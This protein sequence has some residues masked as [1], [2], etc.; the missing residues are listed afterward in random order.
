MPYEQ[1]GSNIV[2]TASAAEMSDFNKNPFI[3]FTGGFPTGFLPSFFLK[4]YWYPPIESDRRGIAKYAPYGLRKIEASLIENGFDD[5]DVAVVHPNDLDR[6]VGSKTRVVG[7]STMDPLGMGFVSS[8]YSSLLGI[9]EPINAM[10]FRKLMQ[11]R[12]LR[13]YK[14]KIIIGGA[15]SWQ[16]ER[17][18]LTE[19]LGVDCVIIGEG[20]EVA[21]EIF[22]KAVRGEAL[23]RV[24]YAK[25]PNYE[26][27]PSI[28]R[29]S[30]YGCV[31]IS[32]GCE[33]N[34]Q[35]CTPTTRH[36]I[37]FPLD[38]IMKEVEI[39]AEGGSNMILLNTEDA[40]L[41][42][43]EEGSFIP[44]RKAVLNLFKKVSSYPEVKI[45]QP[46]HISLASVVADTGLIGD[47][48][49]ILASHTWA[50]HHGKPIIT[51]ETGVES[52]SP[53][54]I[55]K[56]MAGKALPFKP[57]EWNAIVPQAFGILNDNNWYPLAT[58]IVGLPEETEDDVIMTIELVEDL[59]EYRAFFVP[60]LFV[61]LEDCI[62]RN[63]RGANLSSLSRAQWELISL[64]WEYNIDFWR[65]F[66][67]G[68]HK[69][70]F[71]FI[72]GLFY[73]SY[74]KWKVQGKF[75]RRLIMKIAGII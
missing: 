19:A 6:F 75:L 63:E 43:A 51:A 62:L 55:Q 38:K 8:T 16:L 73:L 14:P 26:K 52:G 44:N 28:K 29:A 32:R 58:L 2:L 42:G 66:N 48:S 34:C 47:L 5:S 30:I 36:R 70:F 17:L 7:I 68:L 1:R 41:Y 67:K 54:I 31:E 69:F 27:I 65:S 59:Y 21:P 61:P 72:A 33:R 49:E 40:L 20:E 39:N 24:V 18:K 37:S 9:E 50:K 4:K 46:A 15:G 57:K 60:L 56:Y 35:F 25:S 23:P 11:R 22:S 74:Y 13:K 3:A 71:Q 64:C 10:E 45:I 12:C 53:R